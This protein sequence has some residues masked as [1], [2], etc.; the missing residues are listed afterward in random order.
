MEAAQGFRYSMGSAPRP[1]PIVQVIGGSGWSHAE[2][3]GRALDCLVESDERNTL[4][5]RYLHKPS[6]E[7]GLE[8]RSEGILTEASRGY[9][10][11]LW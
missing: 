8:G 11:K 4:V 1:D 7:A 5:A 10:P 3:P 9:D 6:E 2:I